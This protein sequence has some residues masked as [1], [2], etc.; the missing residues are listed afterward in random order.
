M[1]GCYNGGNEGNNATTQRETKMSH[2][3]T[4]EQIMIAD[5]DYGGFCTACGEEAFG[6]EPDARNYEC[7]SCGERKVFGASELAIMGLVE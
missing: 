6:V 1:M 4:I 3:F 5:N 2:T 7:E